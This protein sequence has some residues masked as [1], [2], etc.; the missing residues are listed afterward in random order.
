MKTLSKGLQLKYSK[1]TQPQIHFFLLQ[2]IVNLLRFRSKTGTAF[3]EVSTGAYNFSE[4]SLR[5]KQKKQQLVRDI[6]VM[7]FQALKCSP[8]DSDRM[9]FISSLTQ[10]TENS[11]VFS[12]VL[13][14]H[15][16]CYSICLFFYFSLQSFL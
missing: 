14:W 2:Y 1:T 9:Q 7:S 6:C 8:A 3:G 12:C 13:N 15:I 10:T 5:K 11:L 4:H 16:D